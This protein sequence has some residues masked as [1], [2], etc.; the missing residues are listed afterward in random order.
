MKKITLLLMLLFSY[1]SNSSDLKD[2]EGYLLVRIIINDPF[3][4]TNTNAGIR[5]LLLNGED[6]HTFEDLKIGVN[7][8]LIK[9][10]VGSYYWDTLKIGAY[11]YYPL[12]KMAFNFQVKEKKINYPGD[13]IITNKGSGTAS[14][15][16]VN[17]ST[18]ALLDLKENHSNIYTKNNVIYSGRG[19]DIFIQENSEE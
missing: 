6:R 19:R 15:D 12:K 14:F 9:T 3:I 5:K 1:N 8:Y 13:L 17:R 4:I 11:S 18:L 16:F 7:S 10:D 2:N